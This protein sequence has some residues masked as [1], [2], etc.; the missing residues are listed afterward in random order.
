MRREHKICFFLAIIISFIIPAT[1]VIIQYSN[2]T[3]DDI[4]S[5]YLC[6]ENPDED[7]ALVGDKDESRIFGLNTFSDTLLLARN[8]LK[9][10]YLSSSQTPSFEQKAIILRC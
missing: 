4:F 9:M 3:E 1:S 2:L 7:D 5:S 6:F 10:G 8:L